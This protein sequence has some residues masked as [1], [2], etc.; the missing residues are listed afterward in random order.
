MPDTIRN[1]FVFLK[2]GEVYTDTFN[3]SGF[4][5]VKGHFTFFIGSNYLKGYVHT[6]SVWDNDRE[7]FIQPKALLPGEVE[8]YTL[9]S[10]SFYSNKIVIEF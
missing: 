5:L 3:L 7:R 9:Y 4:Q 1:R 10:G 6:E 2:S 8:G